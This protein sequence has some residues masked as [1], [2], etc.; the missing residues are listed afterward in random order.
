M[1]EAE[2]QQEQE[3]EILY[4]TVHPNVQTSLRCNKCGRPMCVQCAV[5]T[6]V[7]YR[8][9][10][11]VRGQQAVFYEAGRFDPV[12]QF[13][14]S[15]PLSA[16]AALVI[17]LI[18][19]LLG[20]LF[21]IVWIVAIP[22][23]SFAG[24]LIADLAHRAVGKRRGRYSWLAVAGGMVLGALIVALVPA[25]IL[26]MLYLSA[27]AGDPEY[28]DPY[29]YSPILYSLGSFTSISWWIYIVVGT[30]AAIGRL[31]LGRGGRFRF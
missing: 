10:E 12:V 28:A 7:G 4:C 1:A 31:R 22:A 19:N 24:A 2:I 5:R 3:E 25:L 26:G 27:A 29:A 11:C 15:L 21:F 30:G 16:V 8:C 18:G 9:K 6:P 13:A 14:V 20:G 23:S 17:G